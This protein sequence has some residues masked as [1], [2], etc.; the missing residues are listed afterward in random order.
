MRALRWLLAI[1]LLLGGLVLPARPAVAASNTASS[2]LAQCAQSAS[3]LSALFLFDQSGSLRGS[4]PGGVRFDALRIALDQLGRMTAGASDSLAVEAAVAGFHHRYNPLRDVVRWTRLDLEAFSGDTDEQAKTI[5]RMINLAINRAPAVE[6]AGTAF[7]EALEGAF[8]DMED[9]GGPGRC[10]VVFW[11]TDG[12][13]EHARDSVDKARNRMC[14]PGGLLDQ[15][16]RE[17]IVVIGLQLGDESEDLLSMSEGEGKQQDCGTVPIPSD[18]APGMYVRAD[19][20]AGLKRIFGSVLNT[21][22]GCTT[23]GSLQNHIDPGIRR[24]RV[25]V[26]TPKRV[27]SLRLDAPDGTGIP[28]PLSGTTTENGYVVTPQV[29][30]HYVAADVVIP[31]GRLAG[32]WV[33]TTDPAV[34]I[35]DMSF[36][37]FHD[38]SLALADPKAQLTA[39]AELEVV[40]RAVDSAGAVASLADFG[41]VAAGASALGPDGDLRA[42]AAEVQGDDIII[43]LTT[44]PTDARVEL[45]VTVDLTTKSGLELTPISGRFAL[46]LLLSKE[47]PLVRPADQL[48][49]GTAVKKRPTS[50]TLTLTGSPLGPTR[51]CFAAPTSVVVPQEAAGT[52]PELQVGCVDLKTGEGRDVIATVQPTN[53][54]EGAGSALLPI[55]LHSVDTPEKPSQSVRF[56]LPVA[57]RFSDP[58]NA[59]VLIVVLVVV[60][61]FSFLLPLLALVLANIVSARFETKGLRTGVLPVLVTSDGVRR[62]TPLRSEPE[63]VIDAFGL[64]LT[65]IK[66]AKRFRIDDVEFA[67]KATWN[68]FAA[69]SFTAVVPEGS[70]V[71]SS[72]GLPGDNRTASVSPGLGF[73][74]LAVVSDA[75]L[76]DGTLAK[77]P[78]K[79]VVLLRDDEVAPD[80]LDQIMNQRMN[81]SKIAETWRDGVEID[82]RPNRD[83]LLPTDEPTDPTSY[84]N[85]D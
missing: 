30:D 49:L 79:L 7:E 42:A 64:A 16:R 3:T 62:Q 82:A 41:S 34:T 51:V 27:S 81:W 46:A 54:A 70:R 1:T 78:A 20:A 9:R 23:T 66:N 8:Q 75:D 50:G 53:A 37:V 80:A 4:D 59:P 63:R 31:A 67:A 65:P 38:L 25:T 84:L 77:V 13:F 83:S 72:V 5:D 71:L 52:V 74:V 35:N 55:T 29:D 69:P 12:Q 19:D 39:G 61:L 85:L 56:D 15:I 36:C 21:V 14:E 24:F 57:W 22:L 60:G 58:L 26:E 6:N 28:V 43:T 11:F 18:W 48:D 17:G 33:V 47:F 44:L 2:Y 32:E 40:V 76:A 45:S 68:P 10:R 73:V